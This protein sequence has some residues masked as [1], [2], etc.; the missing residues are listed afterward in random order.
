MD[1]DSPEAAEW[2]SHMRTISAQEH[3]IARLR[4]ALEEIAYPIS[5]LQKRAEADGGVLN[6]A[7]AHSMIQ[8]PNYFRT[9]AKHA[10]EAHS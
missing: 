1:V 8:D 6:A 3:E 5:G 9:L 2:T 4:T 10:L 7:V